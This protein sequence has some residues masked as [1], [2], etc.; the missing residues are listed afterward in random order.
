MTSPLTSLAIHLNL[1][2]LFAVSALVR[3]N[4]ATNA[5]HELSPTLMPV[6]RE[7]EHNK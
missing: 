3:M 2:L 4:I 7:R 5:I 1:K 6:T